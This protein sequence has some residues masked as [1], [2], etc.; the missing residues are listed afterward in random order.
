MNQLKNLRTAISKKDL[1]SIEK[2]ESAVENT[3]K[4]EFSPYSRTEMIGKDINLNKYIKT[5]SVTQLLNAETGSHR[6]FFV[7]KIKKLSVSLSL[8]S[9]FLHYTFL[10][11]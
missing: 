2:Y 11:S 10:L 9:I 1:P 6:D 5:N 8:R 4:E 7:E 3:F